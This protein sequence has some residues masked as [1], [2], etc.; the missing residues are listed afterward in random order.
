MVFASTLLFIHFC[1]HEILGFIFSFALHIHVGVYGPVCISYIVDP[2]EFSIL[3]IHFA[4]FDSVKP[5]SFPEQV[6]N[7]SWLLVTDS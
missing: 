5:G 6:P 7:F 3:I 2:E 4:H 1:R